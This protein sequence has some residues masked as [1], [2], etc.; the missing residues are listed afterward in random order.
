MKRDNGNYCT[1]KLKSK[2]NILFGIASLFGVV[3][4]VLHDSVRETLYTDDE[5]SVAKDWSSIGSDF[6][7]ALDKAIEEEAL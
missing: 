1:I 2:E 3:N 7:N 6:N 4:P 5:D